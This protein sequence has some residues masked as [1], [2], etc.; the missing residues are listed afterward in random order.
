M[1]G[2]T[3]NTK[4]QINPLLWFF[5][6]STIGLTLWTN[7]TG[8]DSDENEDDLLPTEI[9]KVSQSTK[10][11]EKSLLKNESVSNT[12]LPNYA[13][14]SWFVVPRSTNFKTTKALFKFHTW[15][16]KQP[17][18]KMAPPPPPPPEAPPVPF[19]YIGKIAQTDS[20][21]IFLMQN[22]TVFTVNVGESPNAQWRLDAENELT[23][24]FTY[25]PLNLVNVISKKQHAARTGNTEA[26]P[27][28][29]NM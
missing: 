27:K 14:N 1:I 16:I 8:K 2:S 3:R 15:E 17:V 4:S 10:P 25:L 21:Q 19:T 6:V 12:V 20:V 13:N 11:I 9:I 26:Q 23:L 18:V 24:S 7:L 28:D 5:L 29:M 22:D